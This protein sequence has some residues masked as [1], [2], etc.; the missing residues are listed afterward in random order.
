MIPYFLAFT[1]LETKRGLFIKDETMYPE[2]TPAPEDLQI[3]QKPIESIDMQFDPNPLHG[4]K[5]SS[6]FQVVE[7]PKLSRAE[8]R[9][10]EEYDEVR[11]NKRISFVQTSSLMER[12]GKYIQSMAYV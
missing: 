5:S 11:D 4:S 9:Q 1:W 6:V 7:T 10:L 12:T 8:S 3:H 2:L